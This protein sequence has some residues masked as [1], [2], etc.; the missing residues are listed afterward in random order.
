MRIRPA[1]KGS[2]RWRIVL[3][4][5]LLVFLAMAIVSVYLLSNIEKY[6]LSSQ[7]QNIEN[8][9]S[10]SNLLNV[11]AKYDPLADY[12]EE[13]GSLLESAW[14]G[15]SM[16]EV[17][18]VAR[19]MVIVASSNPNVSGKSAAA[20]FDVDLI[21][22]T[23]SSAESSEAI[24]RSGDIDVRSITFPVKGSDGKVSGVVY[25]R[26]DLSGI[27]ASVTS[28]RS[29]FIRATV[30]ALL[31]TVVLS[32]VLAR[33]V[34]VPINDVTR[35]V[36]RMSQG[37]FSS[38]V[39]VKSDDEIGQL[40]TMFNILRR[41]LDETLEEI[42]NEKNKL[43]T[44]LEYMADGLVAI[45]LKGNIMHANPA[46]RE[47]LSIMQDADLS[48]ISYESFM[49]DIS[50]ELSLDKIKE[51]CKEE[52]AQG[53]Y[54][55]DGRIF[56]VRYDRFKDENGEDIGII[57]IIQDITARQKL[58]DMQTDFVANVSHE[59]KTPLTNIKSYTE[60]LLDGA[61]DEH[62][63]AE[64]FLQII[65]SEVDRMNRLVRD[66]LQLSRLDNNQEILSV[67]EANI[68]VLI[69]AAVT[70][71]EL[72]ALAKHQQLNRL[73]DKD[74]D[75]RVNVDR[76]RFEQVMLNVLTNAIK[77]T[78][79]DGRIDVDVFVSQGNARIIVQ[80]NGIGLN[81]EALPRIFERFYRVDRARSRAMGG[82]GLGLAITRQIVES[83]G[84]TITAESQEGKGTKMIIEMPLAIRK[85]VRNIE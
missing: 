76:D 82:T 56:A 33:T 42:S 59:L 75:I 12:P 67:K 36:Q 45:D 11:L 79:D 20:V 7:K 60:T 52:G 74:G 39:P 78:D 48:G 1:V 32:F 53:I 63:T 84:G 83:H 44:I 54:R 49:G 38:E 4:Y 21:A 80:D 64:H 2:V 35:T 47:M 14:V 28:S 17:S 30:L 9:V 22:K 27:K 69:D 68:I 24:G 51:N 50:R 55:Q 5:C 41:K 57:I 65:H 40:A 8:T 70:K 62:E 31:V 73:Y 66:L 81:P 61:V 18:V 25:I 46:A 85:G 6:Q 10:E 13:I 37:D 16:Q 43:G 77:Y 3:I 34:T 26:S 15:G 58:E 19:N 71:V 72:T 23:L 29:I